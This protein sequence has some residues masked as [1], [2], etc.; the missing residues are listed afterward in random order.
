[1]ISCELVEIRD[2]RSRTGDEF[3]AAARDFNAGRNSGAIPFD[4]EAHLIWLKERLQASITRKAA[5]GYDR[6]LVL[7]VF[8]HA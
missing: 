1:M 4:T 7:A 5:K 6:S 2:S 3:D 8:V